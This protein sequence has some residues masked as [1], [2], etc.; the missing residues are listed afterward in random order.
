MKSK[1]LTNRMKHVFLIDDLSKI[2]PEKDTS[3]ALMLEVF[4]VYGEVY[5]THRGN[6][7]IENGH[8]FCQAFFC[9]P[10]DRPKEFFSDIKPVLLGENDISC[11]WIRTDPPFDDAYLIDT[12]LLSIASKQFLVLNSPSG[13]RNL[14][15][16]LWCQYFPDI[17]PQSLITRNQSEYNAFIKEKEQ[18]IV[19]PL[20]GFGGSSVFLLNKE[21][22]NKNVAYETLSTD[23]KKY[24]IVQEYLPEADSGDKRILLLNGEPLG[25]VLRVH[26]REDHRNNFAA[27]GNA[28]S[29][30]ITGQ[31]VK[32]IEQI[33]P[34]LLKEDI[35]L[36]GID[37]IGDKL[38]EVNVTSPTCLRE[39]E[40][41]DNKNYTNRIIVAAEQ[42]WRLQS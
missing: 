13:L 30:T 21:S 1:E 7:S 42:K 23:S 31:D 16:K 8:F 11:F 41:L 29:S 25:A 12:Y 6:I 20:D 40:R 38:V 32:I 17:V 24:V 26:S 10:F 22:K 4:A 39:M 3:F 34:L 19:K 36:A 37:I 9:K 35:F 2:K 33:K 28:V 5:F 27:G 15:E 14:Q 18:F